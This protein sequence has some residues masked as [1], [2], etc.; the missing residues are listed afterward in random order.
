MA[1]SQ[2]KEETLLEIRD[3]ELTI[4]TAKQNALFECIQQIYDLSK[5]VSDSK[6]KENFLRESSNIENIRN[7][8]Q[9]ALENTNRRLL[10]V[11]PTSS[12]NFKPMI[13]F[14]QLYSCIKHLRETCLPTKENSSQHSRDT[15]VTPRKSVPTLPPIELIPFDGEIRSWPLFYA[16]FKSNIHDNPSLTD[17]EKLYYLLGKIT[18]KARSTF[19]GITPSAENYQLLLQT[20][21]D[22]YEDK[23]TLASSHMSQIFDFKPVTCSSADSC[24]LFIDKFGNAVKA[25]QNLK[26]DNLTDMIFLHVALKKLDLDTVRAFEMNS[27]SSPAPTFDSLVLFIK[28]QSNILR[29][30]ET[31]LIGPCSLR[32]SGNTKKPTADRAPAPARPAHKTHNTNN[33]PPQ[34]HTYVN[35]VESTASVKCLCKDITHQHLF[36]CPDFDKMSPEDRFKS[37][38]EINSCV[39][40]LSTKHRVSQCKSKLCCRVCKSKHHTLLHFNRESNPSPVS[41]SQ[42][43]TGTAPT[44]TDQL[45]RAAGSASTSSGDSTPITT[46]RSHTDVSLCATSIAVE[47]APPSHTRVDKPQCNVPST[48]LL[49]TA[50]VAVHDNKGRSH[51]CRAL[52]DSASQ[53]HFITRECCD[54]LGLMRQDVTSTTVKGFGGSEKVA[55]GST[56]FEF[57]SRLNPQIKYNISSLIVDQITESLPTALIDT[58]ALSYLNEIPLADSAFATPNKID[59]LIGASLFPHLLLRDVIKSDDPSAPPAIETVLGY[60]IM[61]SVPTLCNREAPLTACCTIASEPIDTLVKRF[62]QLEELTTSRTQCQ[63]DVEC[64]EFYRATTVR[65]PASGRYTVGLPFRDDMYLLGNSYNIAR[66]RFMCLERKLEA[67]P[68]MRAA[69]DEVIREN[70]EQDYL[71]P[72]SPLLERGDSSLDYV[73]PHHGVIREDKVTTKLRVVI[74]ASAKT[75]SGQS[76]NDLLHSG[77]NLQGDLFEIILNFRLHA[78]ALTADCRQMFMQ[79]V[80]RASDRRFQKIVYRFDPQEPLLLYQFN[81]V[82]FGIK[83]SPFHALRTVKQLVAD[84]GPNY[85]QASQIVSTSLYMDDIVFSVETET[86]AKAVS[87]ELTDLFKGAQWDLVKWNSNSKAALEDL[88]PSHKLVSEVEFDKSVQHKI[89]GLYWSTDCDYFYLKISPTEDKCTKRIILSTIARLWDIM[90][91]VAPSVLYAKLLIKELW[92]LNLGW[93]DAPPPHI[94]KMWRQFCSELPNLN[95]LRIPRYLGVTSDCVVTLLGFSDASEQAYG[96]VIY[97]HVSSADGIRTQLLCA[98]SK[99]APMKPQSIA[100]LELCAIVLLAKLL[101]KVYDTYTDQGFQWIF[102]P[103]LTLESPYI[104]SEAHP[105]VGRRLLRTALSKLQTTSLPTN[106]IMLRAL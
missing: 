69:Y 29:R 99:V 87:K 40:C 25:L 88:P 95:E 44:A 101:R 49:A 103:S 74:D 7:E 77:P 50:Q 12:P 86:E 28:N 8:F 81:R 37:V 11:Q 17:S 105:I 75:D 85:P 90:G 38:K 24:D 21:I 5:D 94:I 57:S 1:K 82:C 79:I 22:K 20:L 41:L 80:V 3:A 51:L 9:L 45:T 100:R 10:I 76:L 78:V 16:S 43:A 34:Y 71:S 53:S 54:R 42:A 66:K 83:S 48:V 32:S 19:S 89:L 61:G 39:N 55:R 30:T 15:S 67:S 2:T 35:T 65:D 96:A 4:L 63:D 6:A 18:G 97:L 52:I 26:V 72:V 92:R 36:K 46:E 68:K 33:F 98:K 104:G 62:W 27:S 93:D 58:S 60:I 91:F 56:S 84:D 59:I 23:R 47:R 31:G 102:T 70:L 73:I 13:A 106:S 64:E 14:E